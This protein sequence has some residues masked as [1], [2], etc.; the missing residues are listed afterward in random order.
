MK[1]AIWS[2][3]CTQKKERETDQHE[4]VVGLHQL[5]YPILFQHHYPCQWWALGPGT[6]LT[7]H[8]VA[9][10][11]AVLTGHKQKVEHLHLHRHTSSMS[12]TKAQCVCMDRQRRQGTRHSRRTHCS[13]RLARPSHDSGNRSSSLQQ[14]AGL[15]E[16]GC[17]SWTASGSV[18]V[19]QRSG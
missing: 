4:T 5:L 7:V 16:F 9:L 14:P 3:V 10:L 6:V 12:Y 17:A 11:T 8:H 2:P 1:E 15:A 13:S 19:R 18:W